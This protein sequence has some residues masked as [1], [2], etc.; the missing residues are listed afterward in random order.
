VEEAV[1][2]QGVAVAL[3]VEPLA[4]MDSQKDMVVIYPRV[5]V[6]AVEVFDHSITAIAHS[7]VSTFSL[8]TSDGRPPDYS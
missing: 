2:I 4:H 7:N 6:E 3:M 8:F 5:L 1:D